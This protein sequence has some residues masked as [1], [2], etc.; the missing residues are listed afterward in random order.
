MIYELDLEKQCGTWVTPHR[1]GRPYL[2]WY[3]AA[4]V[5][6][7]MGYIHEFMLLQREAAA[8]N[9]AIRYNPPVGCDIDVPLTAWQSM[10]V[11][12]DTKHSQRCADFY[13]AVQHAT[14][15]FLPNPA[16][17][18]VSFGSRVCVTPMRD[19]ALLIHRLLEPH[20]VLVQWVLILAAVLFFLGMFRVW[21]THVP[22]RPFPHR[23]LPTPS[24]ATPR[25]WQIEMNAPYQRNITQRAINKN[26]CVLEVLAE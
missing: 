21:W 12:L 9:L 22:K 10:R 2:V 14:S 19:V 4:G 8:T 23:Q 25:A 16:I 26:R 5:L 20:G 17:V 15:W 24:V 13:Y 18:L 3:V 7:V 6:F 1:S 11:A